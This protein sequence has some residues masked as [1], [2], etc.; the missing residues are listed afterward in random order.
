M[1]GS[2]HHTL[3]LLRTV[4]HLRPHQALGQM[5]CRLR[6]WR[7]VSSAPDGLQRRRDVYVM[8]VLPRDC[9][10]EQWALTFLWVR[11]SFTPGNIDWRST[12]QEK[13]W[14]YNL[15]YFDF[16][17]EPLRA[18]STALIENWINANP[19]GTADAWESFPLSLRI[20]NWIKFFLAGTAPLPEA[21]LH[22][23]ALQ[24][25]WLEQN[26]EYHLLAN[27]LFKN[28]K[29]LLFAGVFFQGTAAARWL[30]TGQRLLLEQLAEQILA[31]GGHFERS[32]MYHCMILE[33]CLD[34]LNLCRGS[35]LAQLVP[36][37][38]RLKNVLPAML[39]F[40]E[41]M[42]HPDGGIALFNDAA[43]GIEPGYAELAAYH[44]RLGA[45]PVPGR[46]E[47]V[48]VMPASGY[49]RLAPRPGDVLIMDCGPIGPA[50]Q[51][52]HA[53]CDTLSFELSLAGQRVIV[54]S[55][56]SQY[57]DGEIRR[58]NRGSLGHNG[59]IINGMDQSEVWGAHRVARRAQ[60]IN[61]TAWES[62]KKLACEGAHDGYAHLPGKPIHHR[63]ITWEGTRIEVQDRVEGREEHDIELRLHV[64]PD[65]PVRPIENGVLI[66]VAGTPLLVH[67]LTGNL[68]L[69]HGWYCPQFGCRQESVVVRLRLRVCL[70]WAGGFVMTVHKG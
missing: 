21:W 44:Q 64:H 17:Q 10:G 30:Q 22:S 40:A 52:G 28:A 27:H 15:H 14:R 2:L 23:L 54:D 6:P 46:S 53:H 61:A 16:L 5:L 70:P 29:A 4:R 51:P 60:P 43:L 33:D 3:R 24:A 67:T 48:C 18:N 50:Y 68:E 26:L 66:D 42:T 57:R 47:R 59:L 65:C 9:G 20:V 49:F 39:V 19:Q 37:R 56:C 11:K 32:P 63:R 69:T 8:P 41:A 38:E 45:K 55:G 58:Y 62:G 34:L 25:A 36:L 12:D 31:D 1:M 7:Q 13:L 35:G